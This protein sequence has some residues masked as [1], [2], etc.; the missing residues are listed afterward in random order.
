MSEPYKIILVDDED[1]VRGR[2][3]SKISAESGFQVVG[4]AGN[5][6]DA[7][8][9][10]EQFS[11]HVVLTDI[12]M[13]YINGL[14]LAKII[15]RDHPT[16]RIGFITGYDEFDYA[17]E[18]IELNA[19][20]YLTKP[21]TQEDISRFLCKLKTELD[22]EIRESYNREQIKQRYEQSLPLVIENYFI[23]ILASGV[24]ASAADIEQLRQHGVSLDD[25]DYLLVA[26]MVE[27]QPENWGAV[28]YQK[29]RMAVRA[30]LES[31]LK[32]EQFEHYHFSFHESLVF[33]IKQAGSGFAQQLDLLLNRMVRNT[34]HFL[35]VAI[36]LGVSRLHR[37]FRQLSQAYEE[38]D[39]AL[40]ASRFT[41]LGRVAYI[42]Q[43][44]GPENRQLS[45]K[46]EAAKSLEHTLRYADSEALSAFLDELK[47]SALRTAAIGSGL[48][49]YKLNCATIVANYAT[50]NNVSLS[51]LMGEDVLAAVQ[52]MRSLDQ[53]FAWVHAMAL[54][55]REQGVHAKANNA[56]RM[57]AQAMN[58]VRQRFSDPD[59]TMEEI[60]DQL[61]ISPSYLGQLFKKYADT[62]FVKFLTAI[63]MER[64]KELLC[65][66]GDRIVELAVS[67]GYRDVYYFS[68]SFKKYYG[69]S[70]KKY[71]ED[72]A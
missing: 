6:Y 47:Q 9:L 3:S 1:E 24:A 25:A 31:L 28:E 35:N 8:E 14:E 4:T 43:L 37:D 52:K 7:L 34:E 62:S 58:F 36:E 69:V 45:F 44:L 16:V 26:V 10:I 41:E 64:A 51:E 38:A 40:S 23:S 2:I 57:L 20:S 18:A 13:P 71:R 55:I 22:S 56:Q 50:V 21:L 5:G 60:C 68:H 30:R 33:I 70:P 12:K 27:R 32:L 49:L 53:L 67:C 66:T 42:D 29:L 11:P 63:R 54:R 17:R 59:L 65:T 39:R 61:A 19:R 15:R 48:E 46:E 72:I